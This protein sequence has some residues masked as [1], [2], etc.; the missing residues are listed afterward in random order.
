MRRA[1]C[2][3]AEEKDTL[4]KIIHDGIGGYHIFNRMVRVVFGQRILKHESPEEM[5]AH[6]KQA[7]GLQLPHDSEGALS[8]E[9]LVNS[10]VE[11]SSRWV[12]CVAL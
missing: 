12:R 2:F 11:T 5:Q 8:L 7:A 6:E 4:I 9:D 3:T 1:K 10:T